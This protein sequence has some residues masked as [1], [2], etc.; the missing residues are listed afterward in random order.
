M[1]KKNSFGKEYLRLFLQLLQD[2]MIPV[3]AYLAGWIIVG[4]AA[5][6]LFGETFEALPYG[7]QLLGG[8]AMIGGFWGLA[9]LLPFE[10]SRGSES[11]EGIHPFRLEKT[12]R[13]RFLYWLL[14]V[15]FSAFSGIVLNWLLSLT[16]LT[17]A[18]E[19][20][21]EVASSQFAVPFG[22]GIFLYSVAAPLAEETLFRFMI[23]RRSERTLHNPVA[24]ALLSALLFGLYHGNA[25]QFLY[26]F[27]FGILL[28]ASYLRFGTFLAPL[29]MHALANLAVFLVGTIPEAEEFMMQP[30]R[31]LGAACMTLAGI[32]YLVI[33][34]LQ[35]HKNRNNTR[36]TKESET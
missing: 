7:E 28:A 34:P 29:L 36:K 17:T 3:L 11:A 23:F 22:V 2:V 32:W 8:I 9:V 10:K 21:M 15:I 26:G 30:G 1:E 12:E 20:F 19:T 27:V 13:P 14:L 6:R 25:V 31:L 24:A 16:G 33:E 35:K 5:S 4:T 18:D